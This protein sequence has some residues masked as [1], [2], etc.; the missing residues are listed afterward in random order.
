MHETYGMLH[1]QGT[2][3]KLRIPMSRTRDGRAHWATDEKLMMKKFDFS[4]N[5]ISRI[6]QM[7]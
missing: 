5:F 1:T 2:L 4:L 3:T 7:I 6:T